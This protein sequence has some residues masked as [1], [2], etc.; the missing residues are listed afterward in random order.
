MRTIFNKILITFA[1]I[2]LCSC[3]TAPYHPNTSKILPPSPGSASQ[4]IKQPQASTLR[5]KNKHSKKKDSTFLPQKKLSKSR[6][7]GRHKKEPNKSNK[8]KK[9]RGQGR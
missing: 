6:K 7:Q 1:V 3:T 5:V 4:S 8:D 9:Y 2:S